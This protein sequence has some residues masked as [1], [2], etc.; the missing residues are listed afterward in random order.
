MDKIDAC[1]VKIDFD[2]PLSQT[3]T[4][5]AEVLMID[6]NGERFN[7]PYL[8]LDVPVASVTLPILKKKTVPVTVD[9]VNVPQNFDIGT[10][11]YM[12]EPETIEIAGPVPRINSFMEM[13]LGYI[14]L[15]TLKPDTV[16]L[17]GVNLPLGYITVN[18]VQEISLRFDPK[19]LGE[20]LLNA[21]DIRIINQPPESNVVIQ[22]KTLYGITIYGPKE[23][24]ETLTSLDLV[25]QIDMT[26]VDNRTGSVTVPVTIL[27]PNNTDSWAYGDNHTAVI[28]IEKN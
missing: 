9:F 13:H 20:K 2:K 23:E 27:L 25:A 12:I 26:E 3:G 10:L 19:N 1:Q 18:N 14:D 15:R 5:D 16:I 28:I 17:Y 7:S 11:A 8:E 4:Y 6:Q 24:L 22:T 21:T